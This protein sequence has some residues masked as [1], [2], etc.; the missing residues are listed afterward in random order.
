[1]IAAINIG[2]RIISIGGYSSTGEQLFVV[3]AS[4]SLRFTADQ[5]TVMF[6]ELLELHSTE[7]ISGS[8]LSSVVASLTDV[9]CEVVERLAGRRPIVVDPGIK[10]GFRIEID[11]PG[12]LGADIVAVTAGALAKY[13]P[14]LVVA[15]FTD[16]LVVSAIDKNGSFVGCSICPGVSV[17]RDALVRETETL[18]AV[19]PTG[20]GR[21]IGKSSVESIR[22]G[23]IYGAAAQ[24]EGLGERFRA[25][26]GTADIIV[27][28]EESALIAKA[29]KSEVIHDRGLLHDGLYA[30]YVKNIQTK[31]R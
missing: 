13:E 28:G 5:Y 31:R 26:I 2:N 21:I 19:S 30:I 1:M 22:S 18:P 23:L 8:V 12:E 9:I 29:C 10:T 15:Y 11:N 7:P 27:T 25:E 6:R 3:T 14:P 16:A 20:V 4:T 24:L 17:A